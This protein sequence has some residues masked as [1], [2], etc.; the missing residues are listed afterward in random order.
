MKSWKCLPNPVAL[1][2]VFIL[3]CQTQLSLLLFC[4]CQTRPKGDV[5]STWAHRSGPPSIPRHLPAWYQSTLYSH[6]AKKQPTLKEIEGNLV[7][8]RY[9]EREREK[10]R[11]RRRRHGRVTEI[12]AKKERQLLVEHPKF[13]PVLRLPVVFTSCSCLSKDL[14]PVAHTHTHKMHC[15]LQ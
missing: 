14:G 8:W 4:S 12:E 7:R 13:T 11:E 10:E 5:G 1:H 6:Q 3:V 15:R 9:W 2:S